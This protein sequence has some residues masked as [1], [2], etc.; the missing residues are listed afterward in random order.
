MQ[1]SALCMTSTDCKHT[2]ESS[3]TAE[4]EEHIWLSQFTAQVPWRARARMGAPCHEARCGGSAPVAA[5]QHSTCKCQALTR[6]LHQ[7]FE[8]SLA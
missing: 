4:H 3:K 7:R 6:S 2:H 5:L 1:H 8:L